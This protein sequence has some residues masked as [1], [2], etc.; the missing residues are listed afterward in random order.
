MSSGVPYRGSRP[1][2]QKGTWNQKRTAGKIVDQRVAW[3]N[4][5]KYDFI[6][7]V[8]SD[9][10]NSTQE[11]DPDTP[12][13]RIELRSPGRNNPTVI[14]LTHMTADELYCFERFMQH[15]IDKARPI[16]DLLDRRAQEA[17]D[18]GD[19]SFERLYRA[20]PQF[21]DRERGIKEHGPSVQSGL[22]RFRGERHEFPTGSKSDDSGDAGST[23]P[24]Q[25]EGNV[26]S[27]HD[28]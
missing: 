12:P 28:Q 5:P 3:A 7:F 13:V 9:K 11:F 2:S 26:Q 24:D 8:G 15:A 18:N 14:S 1:P 25:S 6:L 22:E 4:L 23:T 17:F 16:C 21:V 20:V 10:P 19:D 27:E